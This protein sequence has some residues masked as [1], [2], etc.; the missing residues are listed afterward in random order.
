[1]DRKWQ[2]CSES[3][4]HDNVDGDVCVLIRAVPVKLFMIGYSLE[5]VSRNR[6]NRATEAHK[7][8]KLAQNTRQRGGQGS[9]PAATVESLVR[10]PSH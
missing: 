7:C 2:K 9:N 1:M 5:L 10:C 8:E 3:V 4:F 6:T